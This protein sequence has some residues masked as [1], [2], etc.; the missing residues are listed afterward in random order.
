MSSTAADG[1]GGSACGR[2]CSSFSDSTAPLF[3]S[4]K[5][6]SPPPFQS[7]AWQRMWTSR[8]VPF[9]VVTAHT[10][11]RSRDLVRQDLP[12]YRVRSSAAYQ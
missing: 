3:L 8:M 4:S 7:V 5:P 1:S 11:D 12:R 10:G 6:P 2:T 9:S